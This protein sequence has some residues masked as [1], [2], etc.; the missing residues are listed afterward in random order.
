MKKQVINICVAVI[1]NF[2]D[3][4]FACE[5]IASMESLKSGRY[6]FDIWTDDR[7]R[8]EGFFSMNSDILGTYTVRDTYQISEKIGNITFL[9]FHHPLP[10]EYV[11]SE[12]ELIFRIDYLSFDPEWTSKNGAEHIDSTPECTIIELIPSPLES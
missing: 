11:K 12:K 3:M 6:H 7:V 5:L 9:L 2:G 4:G 10:L 8:V 1:D